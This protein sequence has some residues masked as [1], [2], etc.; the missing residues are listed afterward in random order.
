MHIKVVGIGNPLLGDDGFGLAVL[1][2]LEK[3]KVEG[4]EFI[5]LP[6]P[7]PW[8][9]YEVFRE[10]DYFIVVDALYDGDMGRIEIFPISYLKSYQSNL[11]SLHDVSLAQVIDLLSL[12][13]IDI[14][15]V[16]VG[17]RVVDVSPAVGLTETLEKLVNPAVKKV[18]EIIN[19]VSK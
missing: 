9:L 5:K 15:G 16:V 10:G 1:E 18:F 3:D 4:V 19:Q 11:K 17:T 12:Y 14:K 6:T 13:D 2:R 8:Q 7:S